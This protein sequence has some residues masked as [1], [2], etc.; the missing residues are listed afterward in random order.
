MKPLGEVNTGSSHAVEGGFIFDSFGHGAYVERS[1]EADD[2]FHHVT[3]GAIVGQVPDELNVDL[4]VGDWQG[5]EV[6]EAPESGPEV[7]DGQPATQSGETLGK[8]GPCPLIG[9]EGCLGYLEH[10][11]SRVSSGP[12]DFVLD[13][14]QHVW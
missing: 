9:H 4:E 12:E 14:G 6:D 3:I 1:S 13:E 7:I 2:C 5:L 8:I 10:E 11:I